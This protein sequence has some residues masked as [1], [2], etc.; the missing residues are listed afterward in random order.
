MTPIESELRRRIAEARASGR[1]L[2][3]IADKAH[4]GYFRLYNFVNKR[5]P[6]LDVGTADKLYRSLGGRGF[7][8]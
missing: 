6:F 7:K 4:V 8:R 3:D 2:K 1:T 5:S